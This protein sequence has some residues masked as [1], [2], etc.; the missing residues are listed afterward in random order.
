VKALQQPL[1]YAFDDLQ[2]RVPALRIN[3]LCPPLVAWLEIRHSHD[4]VLS[5]ALHVF[6][7]AM[8]SRFG[9]AVETL[10]VFSKCSQSFRPNM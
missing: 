1:T 2:F 9:E 8:A 5:P 4:P 7:N 10:Q 6:R 3:R